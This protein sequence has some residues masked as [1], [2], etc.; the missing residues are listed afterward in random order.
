MYNDLITILILVIRVQVLADDVGKKGNTAAE[1]QHTSQLHRHCNISTVLFFPW[2]FSSSVW[3]ENKSF[4]QVSQLSAS[5]WQ[6]SWRR[7]FTNSRYAGFPRWDKS[8]HISMFQKRSIWCCTP[9]RLLVFRLQR[10]GKI[11]QKSA[12]KFVVWNVFNILHYQNTAQTSP[13]VA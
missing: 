5:G 12:L 7:F 10:N 9:E 1:Q 11:P 8:I 2:P 4:F 3:G 6:S 13:I